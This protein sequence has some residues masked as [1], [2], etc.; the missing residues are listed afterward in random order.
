MTTPR[1]TLLAGAGAALFAPAVRAQPA[2]L[3]IGVLT[4]M[5]GPFSANTGAGSVLAVRMAAEDFG[6]IVGGRPVEVIAAD[7]QNRP[8]TGVAIAREW[9]DR[10]GVSVIADLVNSAVALAVMDVARQKNR[11]TLVAGSG[12]PAINNE[13]CTPT[14]VQLA[15]DTYAT[16]NTA[17]R[18]LIADGRK[19][20]FFVTAD[21]AFGTAAERDA[22]AI[23]KAAGG[24]VLGSVRHP[25]GTTDFSSY[26]LTAQSSGADA[27]AFASAG[28]DSVNAVKQCAEFG[29]TGQVALV[30]LGLVINDVHA[31][32][33]E[34]AR[35]MYL[36]EGFYWNRDD[37]SR[38]FAGRYSKALSKMPNMVQAG[39]YSGVTHWLKAMAATGGGTDAVMAAMRAAP[40]EDAL[41]HGGIV[42]PDG[43]MVHDM[44]LLQVKAPGESKAP[45]DDLKII[46]TVPGKEAFAPL[47]ASR[48]PGVAKR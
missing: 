30:S 31:I 11:I 28:A 12:S 7:H 2:P 47:D 19:R 3:R 41:T 10:Q 21:Y 35:G 43:L 48:C 8:D 16:A 34:A 45:W 42:R 32:G 14:N 6:G 38:A 24:T 29:L 13:G 25:P 9:F 37:A 46:R 4:D 33:L 26:L 15:Y 17:A 22:I 40:V 27:V 20:W 1:R 36:S 39:L 23:I 44:L 5:S 18:S